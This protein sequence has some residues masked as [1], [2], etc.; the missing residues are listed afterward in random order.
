MSVFVRNLF[1]R[2]AKQDVQPVYRDFNGDP[3]GYQKVQ[4]EPGRLV[5]ISATYRF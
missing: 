4:V 5:G 2:E 1:D 3:T